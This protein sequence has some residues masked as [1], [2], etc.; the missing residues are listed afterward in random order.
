MG[1]I[2]LQHREG[3]VRMNYMAAS[4]SC[5]PSSCLYAH[6]QIMKFLPI[7]YASC[8]FALLMRVSLCFVR[9]VL[10]NFN[11]DFNSEYI[12]HSYISVR[13]IHNQK[14]FLSEMLGHSTEKSYW[15]VRDYLFIYLIISTNIIFTIVVNLFFD[16]LHIVRSVIVTVNFKYPT[17]GKI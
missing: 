12:E 5:L 10:H 13:H 14:S 11:E 6:F 8:L 4:S 3:T 9:S 7:C 16:A 15:Y 1:K 17:T 2:L